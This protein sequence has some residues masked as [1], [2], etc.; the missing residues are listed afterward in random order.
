M[1]D[2][3]EAGVWWKKIVAPIYQNNWHEGSVKQHLLYKGG[4]TTS[5]KIHYVKKAVANFNQV[6]GF[7]V[8]S[9][10]TAG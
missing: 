5:M 7:L 8:V 10:S 2:E 9:C 6:V 4:R 1:T 3:E